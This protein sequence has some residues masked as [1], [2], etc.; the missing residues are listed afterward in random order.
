MISEA[1]GTGTRYSEFFTNTADF[2]PKRSRELRIGQGNS[3]RVRAHLVPVEEPSTASTSDI[4]RR[5]R[6]GSF[7]PNC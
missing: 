2:F 1:S 4:G 3:T 7:V 5:Y 6:H